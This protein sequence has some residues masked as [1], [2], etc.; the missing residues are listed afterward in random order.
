VPSAPEDVGKMIYDERRV[1]M[2]KSKLDAMERHNK[3]LR[4]ELSKKDHAFM[5]CG[6][7]CAFLSQILSN[8][9]VTL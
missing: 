5:R 8:E 2:L 4:K 1:V 6:D 9:Y 7:L 3:L